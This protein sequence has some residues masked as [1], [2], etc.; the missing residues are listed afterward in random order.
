M[1][2]LGAGRR[3]AARLGR[4]FVPFREHLRGSGT[5][6]S[7]QEVLELAYLPAA[8][9]ERRAGG[10]LRHRARHAQERRAE[11][12]TFPGLTPTSESGDEASPS[13]SYTG[14]IFGSGAVAVSSGAGSR[15]T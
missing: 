9:R 13:V 14:W 5:A 1:R 7:A 12:A 11:E 4:E 15:M 3:G 10:R 8:V 6:R 2:L